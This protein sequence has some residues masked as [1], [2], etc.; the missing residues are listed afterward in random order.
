MLNRK[1][2]EVEDFIKQHNHV[3]YCE[4]VILPDGRVKYALP[5]HSEVMLAR[6]MELNHFKTREEAYASVTPEE[7]SL[8]WLVNASGYV[9][10]WYDI[11]VIPEGVTPE[12]L[13]SLNRLLE[14]K[15]IADCTKE[16]VY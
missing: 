14:T 6:Y 2:F 4:A 16:L 7:Y 11:Q 1:V 9:A 5:S 3:F 12:Q 15:V 8:Q 13:H 10:I